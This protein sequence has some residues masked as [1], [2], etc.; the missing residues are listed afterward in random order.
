[1]AGIPLEETT[2]EY[3]DKLMSCN[4]AGMFKVTRACLPHMKSGSSFVMTSSVSGLA[5]NAQ[6]SVYS[7]TKFGLIGFA[8]SVA[9]EVGSRG[10]R[11]NIVAPGFIDT[12]TNA[13]V[14]AGKDAV[15]A[16]EKVVAMGRMGDPSEIADVVAFLFSN[17]ARCTSVTSRW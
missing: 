8:R 6:T 3:Y 13:N 16:S 17:E 11:V 9:L 5:P 15:E 10:I 12:P 7:A 14:V 2:D 1:M 4:L